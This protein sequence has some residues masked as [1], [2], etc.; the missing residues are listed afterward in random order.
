ASPECTR[1]DNQL[2]YSHRAGDAGRQI[3]VIARPSA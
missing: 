1:C 2:F 3:A